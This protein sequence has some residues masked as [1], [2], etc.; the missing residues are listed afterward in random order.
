MTTPLRIRRPVLSDD[1]QGIDMRVLLRAGQSGGSLALFEET[2]A[3]NAG[4][5]LH[6]HHAEDEFFHIV[7]GTYRFQAG[8]EVIDGSAGDAL[9]V[10]RG[11]PHCF[12]NVGDQTGR[13]F[14]G[15]VPGGGEAFFD[16]LAENGMPSG[17]AEEAAMLMDRYAVEFLGPNPFVLPG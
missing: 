14:M 12:C 1:P 3:P 4:P 6:V 9:F 7:A 5:P 10:P 11:T 2:T 15:F 13:L 17:P 8:D 16:W